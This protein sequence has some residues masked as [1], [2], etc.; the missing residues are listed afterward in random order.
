MPLT[1]Q[2]KCI[3]LDNVDRPGAKESN[4]AKSSIAEVCLFSVITGEGCQ[5]VKNAKLLKAERANLR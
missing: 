1:L 5:L 3:N 4:N 2:P